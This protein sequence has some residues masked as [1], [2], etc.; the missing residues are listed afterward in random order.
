MQQSNTIFCGNGMAFAMPF[1]VLSG[2]RFAWSRRQPLKISAP[3]PKDGGHGKAMLF[4]PN[5]MALVVPLP[6]RRGEAPAR[7]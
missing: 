5:G 7:P 6:G 4:F 3:V 2:F 1:P